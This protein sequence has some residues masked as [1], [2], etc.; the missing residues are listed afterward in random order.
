MKI[1]S[2]SDYFQNA[3]NTI[4]RKIEAYSDEEI[5][6]IID[7]GKFDKFLQRYLLPLIEK[8]DSRKIELDKGKS[9][10]GTILLKV[11]YPVI[12]KEKLDVVVKSNANH[13]Y[14]GASF[15]YQLQSDCILLFTEFKGKNF[16][17]NEVAKLEQEISWKNADVKKENERIRQT[18][19]LLFQNKYDRVKREYNQLEELIKQSDIRYGIVK[20]ESSSGTANEKID[21]KGF[22][23]PKPTMLKQVADKKYNY[24]FFISHASEDK[25]SFVRLLATELQEKGYNV[26]YDEFTLTLGDS[27]RRKIDHG[28]ANSCFGIVVLSKDFFRKEWPQKELDGL[29][30]RERDGKKVILPIWH[31]VTKEDVINFSPILAGRLAASTD[32]GLDYVVKEIIRAVENY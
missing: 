5:V 23:N 24:D 25:E 22:S 27:L 11:L 14:I 21:D 18:T 15:K 6:R 12:S 20:K 4:K 1:L 19:K 28:L 29:V 7:E 17:D 32:E 31:G 30:A 8:D 16:L 13:R 2:I 9:S 10:Y 3:E 26:W